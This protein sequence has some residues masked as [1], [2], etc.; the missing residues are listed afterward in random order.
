MKNFFTYIF[1]F[2]F[3]AIFISGCSRKKDKFLNKKFHSLTTTYNYLFNG[4]NL[5]SL[6]SEELNNSVKEN[7]WKLI[8][9]E[10]YKYIDT[11][12]DEDRE[13]NFTKAEEKATL[14]IQKHSMNVAGKEKNPV[15]DEAYLLL[16]KSRYFDNRFIPALEAF[17][18]ILY[19]YPT[20]ELINQVKIWKE[21]VN[22]R[23]DQNKYAIDNLKE[24]LEENN[25]SK[26]ERSSAHSYIS[27]AFISIEQLD[28]SLF[29]LKKSIFK[30]KD[31]VINTRKKFLLAQLYQELLV[32]DTAYT[33]Y[34]EIIDLH[35]KIPR[36][37]YVNSYIKRSMVSDSID[38]SLLELE[39]LAENFE[40]NNFLD[41]IFHQL[42]MLNLKKRDLIQNEE[43]MFQKLDSIA[44]TYFN[45]SLRT[46][47]NEPFLVA[48]NYNEL[49][50]LNF[51]NKNY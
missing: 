11:D 31:L 50:E 42:A 29:Y 41:I 46:D 51:R 25:L 14:A 48:K 38:N 12:L 33:L 28:S 27:Q 24:L 19:K 35:R 6:G 3:A 20:S 30:Q 40:N 1:L 4:E 9:I 8:P 23:I 43:I 10:K 49:A 32:T 36:E 18:Y 45:K 26:E 13:T 39:L 2:F 22:I 16:G 34:S 21:K 17:N 5:Y 37:F 7:F 15:M 47:S 44:V